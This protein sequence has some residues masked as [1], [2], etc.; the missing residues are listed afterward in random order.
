MSKIEKALN[1]IGLFHSPKKEYEAIIAPLKES[2]DVASKS[3]GIDADSLKWMVA[4][5]MARYSHDK[6]EA[7]CLS[8]AEFFVSDIVPSFN[9]GIA[10]SR[11]KVQD[12][13]GGYAVAWMEANAVPPHDVISLAEAERIWGKTNLRNFGKG[14]IYMWQSGKVWLTTRQTMTKFYGEPKPQ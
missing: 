3:G 7:D 10:T 2:F 5:A 14:R 11:N 1:L 6:A 8:F 9:G 4:G 12:F 13:L